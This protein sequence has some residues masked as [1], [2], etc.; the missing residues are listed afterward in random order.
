MPADVNRRLVLKGVAGAATAAGVGPAALGQTQGEQP[1]RRPLRAGV[2]GAGWFGK[3]NAYALMQVTSAQIIALA[4]VDQ[5][6]LGEA[7]DL[8][9]AR[10]DAVTAPSQP[11]ALYTDYREMLAAHE[12]DIV[13]IGTPDHWHALP[14]IAA[15][16]AG[17]NVYLEK[18]MCVDVREGQAMV[19]A[20]HANNSVVQVN[21]QRR[22]TPH[23]IEA[24]QRIIEAGLLGTIGMVEVFGYFHQRPAHF[25]PDGQAPEGLDWDTYC[26]PA[27]LRA[28]NPDIH[29]QNWRAFWA[30]GNGYL[31]DIGVHFIDTARWMLNLGWPERVSSTGGVYVDTDSAATVPDTQVATF[32]F[33][34][35]LMTWTNRH[36]GGA[37]D[38]DYTWGMV[39]HGDRGSLKISSERYEFVPFGDG[40]ALSGATQDDTGDFPAD[41]ALRVWE[42][43]L[44]AMNRRHMRDFL[45]AIEAGTQPA[46]NIDDAFASTGSCALANLALKLGRPLRW[47]AER[48][49]VIDDDEANAQLAREYRAPWVHPFEGT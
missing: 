13:I 42:R 44:Q 35:M 1:Q 17:A 15:M 32:E 12:F 46:A 49:Q 19:A 18:P 7:R 27:P 8:I 39:I 40:Q 16:N 11:P 22:T 29:P 45:Q 6:M 33:D 37:A 36:W 2:I 34:D 21:T 28:Y 26:G 24:K 41:E 23:M 31:G 48:A 3:L 47:D 14:A 9:T 25:P 20:A 10:D 43:P 30:F 38:P 4:D 5:Y